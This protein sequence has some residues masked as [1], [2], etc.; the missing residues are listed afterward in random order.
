[1][2]RLKECA[3]GNA[4]E[5]N[6]DNPKIFH[7]S[8]KIQR[9]E[10]LFTQIVTVVRIGNLVETDHRQKQTM[11]SENRFQ[12]R[13]QTIQKLNST[14]SEQHPRHITRYHFTDKFFLYA[15]AHLLYANRFL[16]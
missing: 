10:L 13:V 16:V 11:E 6:T 8:N 7:S 3:Q 9:C 4:H 14:I 15:N 5:W 1:M 2:I 12:H